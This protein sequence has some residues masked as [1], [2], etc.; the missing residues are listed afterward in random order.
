MPVDFRCLVN[1]GTTGVNSLPQTVTRQRR[2][3]DLNPGPSAPESS[4]LTSRLSS[5]HFSTIHKLH[6]TSLLRNFQFLDVLKSI[7]VVT[8]FSCARQPAPLRTTFTNRLSP[9]TNG[10][11]ETSHY[12]KNTGA[13]MNN[14]HE[15]IGV[16]WCRNVSA[17]PTIS[18]PS[19]VTPGDGGNICTPRVGV[20][21]LR[22]DI[23]ARRR[24]PKIY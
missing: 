13:R 23:I 7:P 19:S 10:G 6:A 21:A 1:R 2:G 8:Y 16:V 11:N 17:R 4:T 24:R 20:T 5:H 9:R 3:C 18:A 12:R 22:G 14:E 15:W